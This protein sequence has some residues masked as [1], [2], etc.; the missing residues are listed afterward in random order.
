MPT[1]I[2]VWAVVWALVA[3]GIAVVGVRRGHPLWAR[4]GLVTM[5]GFLA[6]Q[7][8]A[9]LVLQMASTGQSASFSDGV[10]GLV[11]PH[12]RSHMYGGAV[13]ALAGM[14]P[15]VLVAHGALRRAEAWAWWGL[16][17]FW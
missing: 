5:G 8:D 7:A 2:A 15:A 12:A 17:G 3:A 14:G 1:I 13:Q 16:A 11:D 9:Q 10:L 4:V 6:G